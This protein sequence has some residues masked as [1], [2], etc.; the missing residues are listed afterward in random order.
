MILQAVDRLAL[1]P[2][3][4][5]GVPVRCGALNGRGKPIV[6]LL[7]MLGLGLLAI[8]PRP[9]TGSVEVLLDPGDY[10]PRPS[11]RPR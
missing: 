9:E 10:R 8:D 2:K 3:V 5:V 11:K 4:Y 1:S 6:R 7:R